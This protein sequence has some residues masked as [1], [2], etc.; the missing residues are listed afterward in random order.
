MKK[1]TILSFIFAISVLSG[2]ADTYITSDNIGDYTSFSQNKIPNDTYIFSGN[3]TTNLQ[4]NNSYK[5]GVESNANVSFSARTKTSSA[6]LSRGAP[7]A[8]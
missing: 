7:R 3:V 1:L 6:F 5:M 2:F 8:L 4:W